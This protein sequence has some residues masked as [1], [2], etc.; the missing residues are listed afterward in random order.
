LDGITASAFNALPGRAGSF[1]YGKE[2]WVFLKIMDTH[3]VKI[4]FEG[5]VFGLIH[6]IITL[7]LASS[8]QAKFVTNVMTAHVWFLRS[9]GVAFLSTALLSLWMTEAI[10]R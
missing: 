4:I 3:Q 5:K 2:V 6:C 10:L 1:T 9:L 8:T 7:Y